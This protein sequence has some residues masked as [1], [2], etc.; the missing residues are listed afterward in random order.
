MERKIGMVSLGCPKNQIDA[1]HILADLKGKGYAIASQAA[2]CDVVIINTCGF[3]DAAKAEA[4]ENILEFAQLKEEGR[5][6]GVVVTGC[7]SERYRQ[8]ILEEIPEVD[9]VVGIGANQSIPDIVEQVLEGKT[10]LEQYGE[11][12]AL[13]LEGERLLS[14][15]PYTAYLKIAEGCS[16]HCTYCAIPSIRG[17]FRSR[18]MENIVEE[19]KTLAAQGVKELIL[20]AQDTTNYGSDLYGRYALTDLLKQLF[21]IKEFSWIRLLYCYPD[22]IT[23]ELLELMKGDNPLLPYLDLPLQHCA[24]G[25]LKRMHRPMLGEETKQ[26]LAHI[27]QTVP[28]ITL[29]TTLIAGFPGETE[30]EFEQLCRFVKE[31]KFD[32]LG[33]FAYSQEEGT[34]AAK[35]PEQL[36]EEVKQ[37]RA[38]LVMEYQGRIMDRLSKRKIGST[39]PVMLEGYD[40][41]NR[42]CYGRSEADA[43][44]IDCKVFFQ[45]V[46]HHHTGEIIQ[47]EITDTMDGDLLGREAGLPKRGK[48]G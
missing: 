11:K 18:P 13:S 28:N 16:N 2:D 10:H 38:E 7:L 47:V 34:P 39:I 6:K 5:I 22:K 29:R 25:V 41:M 12:T 36:E 1:E 43:P 4:I 40:R 9:A 42:C 30:Q 3:I 17:P 8:Q 35:L 33:C 37:R 26:L 15:P 44:D 20:V 31:M 27:R 45:A 14:T 48:Q 24:D 21:E 19:A 32:R 23:D 46:G